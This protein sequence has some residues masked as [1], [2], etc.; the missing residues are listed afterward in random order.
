[1]R[2]CLSLLFLSSLLAGCGGGSS[3]SVRRVDFWLMT[4]V[5][6]GSASTVTVQEKHCSADDTHGHGSSN[7]GC[8]PPYAPTNLAVSPSC[9]GS[10][11]TSIAPSTF[12]VT[13][14]VSS[15]TQC[16][17]RIVDL[18]TLVGTS[19]TVV[20][21]VTPDPGPA[22]WPPCAPSATVTVGDTMISPASGSA[23]TASTTSI[24]VPR[25]KGVDGATLLFRDDLGRVTSGGVFTAGGSAGETAT[26]PALQPIP[27][28]NWTNYEVYTI[29]VPCGPTINFGEFIRPPG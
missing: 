14:I 3:P 10:T 27:F 18:K 26:T 13:T 2:L 17:L 9:T 4:V 25:V 28:G 23:I 11:V 19:A 29:G 20:G 1:M 24:T 16:F 6:S 21:V 5:P 12:S 15:P 7:V 8:D 22:A